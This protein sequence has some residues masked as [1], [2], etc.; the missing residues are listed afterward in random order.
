MPAA[1]LAALAALHIHRET[2]L[3][4]PPSSCVAEKS[5]ADVHDTEIAQRISQIFLGHFDQA[6]SQMMSGNRA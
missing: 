1:G 5:G 6:M 3:D 4:C 2:F